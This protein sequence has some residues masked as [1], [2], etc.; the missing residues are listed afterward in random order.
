MQRSV[1]VFCSPDKPFT[2][3]SIKASMNSDFSFIV[4]L[5]FFEYC[6]ELSNGFIC[7]SVFVLIFKACPPN[8]LIKG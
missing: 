7:V 1:R 6:I 5:S 8:A 2:I 4:S 3:D